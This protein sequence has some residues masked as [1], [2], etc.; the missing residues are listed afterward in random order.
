MWFGCVCVPEGYHI[1]PRYV[2]PGSVIRLAL[3]LGIDDNSIDFVQFN[4][5][6]LNTASGC[7]TTNVYQ[8]RCKR[9]QSTIIDKLFSS[10]PLSVEN[11][12]AK[13][14]NVIRR[15]SGHTGARQW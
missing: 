15:W 5:R 10:Q 13:R 7:F 11:A 12:V 4:R 6:I 8:S 9:R 2:C 14:R 3:S 1:V